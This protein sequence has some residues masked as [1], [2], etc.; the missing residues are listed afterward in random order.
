MLLSKDRLQKLEVIWEDYPDGLEL[1][2]F[3]QLM[4][5]S[6]ECTEEEKYELVHG[7]LK[8]FSEIDINGDAHMEWSEFMQ[9]IIDAVL[10]NSIS[11]SNDENKVSVMELIQQMKANK[12]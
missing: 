1:P 2:M 8:L 4:I 11:S 3:T 6:I 12:F 10:E 5:D 7:A 9:Y